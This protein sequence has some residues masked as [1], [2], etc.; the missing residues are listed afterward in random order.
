MTVIDTEDI[1]SPPATPPT[2]SPIPHRI[3][4]FQCEEKDHLAHLIS[5]FQHLTPIQK[6]LFLAE[7]INLCNNTQLTFLNNLIAPRLKVDFIKELPP[8][9]ALHVLSYIDHPAAL[10]QAAQISRYWNALIKNETL[11]KTLCER[12]QYS[13]QVDSCRYHFKRQYSIRRAWRN[14]GKVTTVEG[15]FSHGLVTS[16]QF[17]EKYT[18]VGCDNHRVEVFD[19]NSGKKIKTLEGHEGGVWALQFKGEDDDG[20]ILLSGGCD[21]DVRVWDLN[22]GKLKH[23]LR[24]HT[25]TV[26]CLKIRD[27]QLAVTGSRDTTLRV[28]DIQ[29]GALLHTLVGHQAS[30]RCVDI[31]GDIAVSGSYDFTARV[32]DLKTG[33]C[34]HILVGHTLQIYTIVTNGT[35]IATGAMDAH[36]RIWSVETGECLATLHGHTSLVGQLQLSGTTLVSGGA[37]G[38]LRVWDMETFECKQQ[39]SAHDNSIT[40]LQFDDQ[41]IL[42]AANDGKVKL[43]DIKRGRLIRNFTQPSKIVWKIQ[44][45]QTKAVVLM[46]RKRADDE[47]QGRTVMEIHDFDLL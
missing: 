11:W 13:T 39:F 2:Q 46:Q 26:R 37:D 19:T 22:Q 3:S 33:R 7:I 8:E 28:W 21:R 31:H 44:F 38:C 6:Q 1:T 4:I 17:D 10:T 27:K 24:G 41:H 15:E 30:V 25:S 42:S 32:W 43:W 16:L 36:I 35:I 34:K 14:G 45:N 20:R 40:C 47:S 18:V 9:I 29:R 5:S 23:I 12:Y